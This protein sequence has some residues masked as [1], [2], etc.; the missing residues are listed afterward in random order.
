MRNFVLDAILIVMFVAEM[1]FH[2]L[3]KILH[4]IIGVAMAAAI[5]IHVFINRRR[6]IFLL[7]KVT[8]RKILSA[9]VNFAL[10]ICAAIIFATGVCMS[11]YLF[12]DVISF[13]LRR[14]M[15]LHQ[16]HVATPYA[17]LILIG[18]HIGLHWRE[19]WQRFLKLVGAEELYLRRRII[20]KAAAVILSAVGLWGFYMNRVGDRILMKHIFATPATELPAAIFILLTTGGVV[21]FALITFLLAERIKGR[22]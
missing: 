12:I 20:F 1:S 18:V 17:L 2:F 11:N 15:T 19:F 21:F 5:F 10:G 13:E 16:L 9:L 3:P 7:K 14:N 8:V 22:D 6:F 4:E